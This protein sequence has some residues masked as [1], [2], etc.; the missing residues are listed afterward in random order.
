MTPTRRCVKLSPTGSPWNFVTARDSGVFQLLRSLLLE[1]REG[2]N[3]A[4]QC[5]V[6]SWI[7]GTVTCYVGTVAG[8]F[9]TIPT[10]LT[11]LMFVPSHCDAA[12]VLLPGIACASR[13]ERP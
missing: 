6:V 12:S 8:R 9:L 1:T 10:P 5:F 4:G 2:K 3:K 13:T 11:L 7:A